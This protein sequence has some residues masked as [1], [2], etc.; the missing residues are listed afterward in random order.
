MDLRTF[1]ERK[2]SGLGDDLGVKTEQREELGKLPD[3]LM[4]SA[5]KGMIW[6][7]GETE[8]M[9]GPVALQWL[10]DSQEEIKTVGTRCCC[11]VAEGV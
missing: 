3:S 2:S 8:F 7:E 11:L 5:E 9:L 6:R 4:L 1:E 10:F